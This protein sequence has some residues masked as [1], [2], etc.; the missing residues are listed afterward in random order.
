MVRAAVWPLGEFRTAEQA[1]IGKC[2][3]WHIVNVLLRK[4]LQAGAGL[5]SHRGG[6]YPAW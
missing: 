4:E 6:I 3:V 2:L 5:V 1:F